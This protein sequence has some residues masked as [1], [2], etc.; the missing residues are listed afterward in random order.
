MRMRTW[1]VWQ[2]VAVCAVIGA[3]AAG[4][5]SWRIPNVY[6]SSA[7][8]RM[9]ADGSVAREWLGKML[10][11]A[12]SEITLSRLVTTMGL[13]EAERAQ[14]PI[15]DVVREMRARTY[16]SVV[17]NHAGAFKV[18]YRGSSPEQARL[19]AN[20]LVSR[21]IDANVEARDAGHVSGPS[22]LEVLDPATLPQRPRFP[23]RP[24][25]MTVGTFLGV[26]LGLFAFQL[27]AWSKRSAN[28]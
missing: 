6:E 12:W 1:G 20:L 14:R 11:N 17:A 21:I 16:V 28:A 18:S 9:G 4:V 22:R 24:M 3:V 15:E 26:M 10:P 13:Y 27:T 23:N 5:M 25:M 19:V 8:L 2:F 7:V